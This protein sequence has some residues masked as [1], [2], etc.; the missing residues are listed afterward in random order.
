MKLPKSIVIGLFLN[1]IK[2]QNMLG[3]T[4]DGTFG[5]G[6][7]A[8]MQEGMLGMAGG[9]TMGPGGMAEMQGM[10]APS[11]DTVWSQVQDKSRGMSA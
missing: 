9:V 4:R 5:T 7:V 3:M 11:F 10:G 6:G 1:Q 2:A 8:G